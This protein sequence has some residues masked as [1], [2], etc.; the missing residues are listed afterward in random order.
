[1]GEVVLH[2]ENIRLGEEDKT[3]RVRDSR[4]TGMVV[5]VVCWVGQTRWCLTV[6]ELGND[7]TLSAGSGTC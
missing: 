1:M 5:V 3:W 7:D 4:R 2:T 6:R